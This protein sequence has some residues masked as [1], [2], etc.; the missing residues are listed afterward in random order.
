MRLGGIRIA[1]ATAAVRRLVRCWLVA[2]TVLN[3]GWFFI[4]SVATIGGVVGA[5][6]RARRV[7]DTARSWIQRWPIAVT[8]GAPVDAWR[9]ERYLYRRSAWH[10]LGRWHVREAFIVK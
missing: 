7:G 10:L 8:G 4:V 5:T 6:R 2:V 9:I 3:L 1:I